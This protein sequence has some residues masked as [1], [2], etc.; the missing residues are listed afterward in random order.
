LSFHPAYFK[1]RFIVEQL[2]STWPA[3]FVIVTAYATT[4]EQWS[5]AQNERADEAL[6][7]RLAPLGVWYARVTGHDATSGHAEPGWAFEADL[8]TGVELGREFRQDAIYRVDGDS[9]RVVSC[10]DGGVAAVGGFR[11]RIDGALS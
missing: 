7:E 2:P 1:T 3:S 5:D 4:G 6:R 10:A 8:A 9:L 11:E